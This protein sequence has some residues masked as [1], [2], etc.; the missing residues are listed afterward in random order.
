MTQGFRDCI[1]QVPLSEFIIEIVG[2]KLII[3]DKKIIEQE[4]TLAFTKSLNAIA[5]AY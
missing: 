5:K 2:N 1:M 3:G 4:S